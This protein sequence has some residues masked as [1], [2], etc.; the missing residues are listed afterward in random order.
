VPISAA[1]A[2]VACA[3]VGEKIPARRTKA[4]LSILFAL[5]FCGAAFFY[6]RPFYRSWATPL[7]AA[8][9]QLQRTTRP[10]ALI[11]AADLGD[12]ALLYYAGRRGWHLPEKDAIYNGDPAS[13][14]QLIS[15]V[16]QL[17][18]AGATHLVF[19]S[20]TFW[21][22]DRYRDFAEYLARTA[23]LMERT[24]EFAIYE[25]KPEQ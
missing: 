14:D 3:L 4:S 23:M 21:F 17:R 24:P 10:G 22:V 8:G 12:P 15:D 7:R 19:V 25:L 9:I 2:G 13:A 20:S 1:F 18:K 11:I 5:L 16:A 6:V